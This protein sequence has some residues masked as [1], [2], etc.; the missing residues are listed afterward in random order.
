MMW[1]LL[2]LS[3]L[4]FFTMSGYSQTII[5]GK[6]HDGDLKPIANVNVSYKTVGG[7]PILSYVRSDQDGVFKL[8]IKSSAI[9]SLQLDFS[10]LSYD[11]KLVILPNQTAHSSYELKESSQQLEDVKVANLPVFIR[12][13]TLNYNVDAFTSKNDRVIGDIIK[14]LPGI[15]MRGDQILYQGKPI[16]K[17]MVNNLDLMEGRYGMINKNLPADAVKN[18]QVVENDQPIKVLDSLVFSDRASLNL[19]L[20]KSTTTGSGK[21]GIGAS[22]ALWDINLTP[23]TFGKTFQMVNSFQTN[24]VGYNATREL[25]VF[26]T[27]SHYISEDASIKDAPSYVS[28]QNVSSPGFDEK[29]WLDNRLF[30]FSSNMLQKLKSGLE[31]KGNISY[32]DDLQKRSGF[33]S[34]QY[35]TP[36][37]TILTTEAMDNRF[38]TNVFDVGL[39]I[40]KNEENVF[41]R[42]S[43]KYHKK[44]S[45]DRGN[46][47]FDE[48]DIITQRK[49]YT[50][51]ALLNSLSLARFVG[52]QLVNIKS[53]VEWHRTPQ[54]LSVMPGQFI[55]ILHNGDSYDGMTQN[56]FHKGLRTDNGVSFI[57]QF[58]K[59]WT[60]SPSANINYQ[61]HTLETVMSIHDKGENETLGEGYLNDI[62]ASQLNLSIG[63]RLA[64][65]KDKWR[66]SLTTPYN[67]YVYN[68]EQRAL[69][70]MSNSRRT[71]FNP[72]FS[73]TYLL[74][75]KHELSANIA[76]GRE[77]GGLNNF[78]D[79]YII[80]MYRSL[81]RY[82]ARLLESQSSSA[83]VRYHYKNTQKANFANFEYVYAHDNRDYIYRN[84]I[85]AQG[86]T[87][88]SIVDRESSNA[89][90]RLSGGVS[91][92]FFSTK[93]VA[94]LNGNIGWS[95]SDYLLNDVLDKQKVNTSEGSL[96]LINSLF[97]FISGE[98]KATWGRVRSR[99][100]NGRGNKVTYANQYLNLSVY[101]A[102]RHALIFYNSYYGN[103]IGGQKNQ[104]FLDATY[105][106]RVEKL[107][108]DI[109]LT[110]QNLLNN[111]QYIQ[112]VSSD[113]QLVQSYFDLRPRQFLLSTKFRF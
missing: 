47:L 106:Y 105:R 11:R 58:K 85:D 30:L 62:W 13:D 87:T 68:V 101:P 35:F 71:N 7:G 42:N 52:K 17:Y 90:H 10:H 22:P 20:K 113:Y 43:I 50:D 104:Y 66:L 6:I 60:V 9:D 61:Q 27:G 23:M 95:Q 109:E 32:Y 93:T 89:R 107:N 92:F 83:S 49:N 45:D 80:N 33:T 97:P 24:N 98:Y 102:E 3:L 81:Q 39:L 44:W 8:T 67:F 48:K 64:F 94:K 14:K 41:L 100:A 36:D 99:L 46:V 73:S 29:K 38:R 37:N 2:T 72:S 55:D 79:A 54:K 34:I 31:L 15:E 76:T 63:S 96:E 28:L 21:I 69:K 84:Q 70:T 91:R 77:F 75:L 110:T 86:L 18:V 112:Q 1:K 19:T 65:Q 16:Q 108:T 26:Y 53:V 57:K 59:Y 56:V 5:S 12:R 103:N 82:E 74:S 88:I 78:Y 111:S 51:E 4:L 40:E 25:Q